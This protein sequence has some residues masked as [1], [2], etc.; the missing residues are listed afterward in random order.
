MWSWLAGGW[1]LTQY[2][3]LQSGMPA[4]LP[5]GARYFNDAGVRPVD[6]SADRVALYRPCIAGINEDGTIVPQ[7]FSL[8]AGCGTDVSKYNFPIPPASA[9]RETPYRSHNVRLHSL[10]NLDL[11]INKTT[12]ITE[13]TR[14]QFRA[15]AFNATN[16]NF[17]G[18]QQPNTNINSADFGVIIRRSVVAWNGNFPRHIQV[19]V[20]FIWQ[21]RGR[22][23][24]PECG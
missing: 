10:L 9:P 7:A 15:E 20:K 16:T 3:T 19:A 21:G 1:E 4:S 17:F 18:R 11:S 13:G 12:R 14:I 23:G 8:A 24:G 5:S 6:W 22:R 2:I